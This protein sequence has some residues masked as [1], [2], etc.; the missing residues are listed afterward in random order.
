MEKTNTPSNM[1][2]HFDRITTTTS[3]VVAAR[4]ISCAA[5]SPPLSSKRKYFAGEDFE[6]IVIKKSKIADTRETKEEPIS[7][8]Y[9]NFGNGLS[10]CNN[11][12]TNRFT[13][14]EDILRYISW[15]ETET[16]NENH[17]NDDINDTTLSEDILN[18]F[19]AD[20]TQ[21][22]ELPELNLNLWDLRDMLRL[23]LV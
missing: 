19:I 21:T 14:F 8:L 4:P 16:N 3:T 22:K 15:D 23:D 9:K 10:F 2:L 17:C 6:Q 12:K 11:T 5:Q 7:P 18:E 1:L 20:L 13:N